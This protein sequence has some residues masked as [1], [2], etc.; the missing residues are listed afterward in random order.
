MLLIG[1]SCVSEEEE[2]TQMAIWCISAA[3]LIMGNDPRSISD[4]SM[5]ILTN[6][7]AIAVNQDPLG[8]MGIRLDANSTPTQ[9][10]ARTLLN[11]DVAVALYNRGDASGAAADI[12]IAFSDVNLVGNVKIF[13]IW[14]KADMGIFNGSFTAVSVPFHDSRFLRLSQA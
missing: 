5:A 6:Q 12:T 1:N 13:D 11:G 8:Q 9:R 10:W 14:A 7:Y 4:T 3:P 2:R